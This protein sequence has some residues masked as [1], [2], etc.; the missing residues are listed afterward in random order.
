[1]KKVIIFI[2]AIGLIVFGYM[3]YMKFSDRTV[4]TLSKY[5]S[6]GDEVKQIQQKLKNW[7]YYSGSV[8]RKIW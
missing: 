5:G 2:I 7:G 1:M 8:D 4:E 3:Y 6:S